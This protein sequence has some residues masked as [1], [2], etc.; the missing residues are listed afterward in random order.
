MFIALLSGRRWVPSRTGSP[1]VVRDVIGPVNG[2]GFDG[3]QPRAIF[4]G[5]HK[6]SVL[7]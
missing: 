3:L 4:A 6:A 1:T 5:C 7:A 2:F